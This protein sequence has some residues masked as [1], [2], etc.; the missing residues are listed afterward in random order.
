MNAVELLEQALKRADVLGFFNDL[1][2]QHEARLF[3][4]HRGDEL[5]GDR[6]R[7]ALAV[8]GD[9]QQPR[10]RLAVG[11]AHLQRLVP[12]DGGG[13]VP[14]I[15]LGLLV[16]VDEFGEAVGQSLFEQGFFGVGH[17]HLVC[18]AN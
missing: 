17:S 12:V 1:T 14:E 13:L 16:Q 2:R 8:V 3:V 10:Q 5:A 18:V 9:R 15:A 6:H 4:A 7:S 11:L